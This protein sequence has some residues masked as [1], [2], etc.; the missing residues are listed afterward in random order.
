MVIGPDSVDPLQASR[1][2]SLDRK[3][4]QLKCLH[5]DQ[6]KGSW[7]AAF[8]YF[9]CQSIGVIELDVVIFLYK[10]KINFNMVDRC[11]L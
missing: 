8:G 3:L 7:T 4:E 1:I 11:L 5:V 9:A 10:F 2:S 6:C